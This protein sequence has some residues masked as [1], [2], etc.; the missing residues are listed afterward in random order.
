MSSKWD[1]YHKIRPYLNK[2]DETFFIQR[3][4]DFFSEYKINSINK[5]NVL[6]IGSGHGKFTNIFLQIFKQLTS[7]EPNIELY[8]KLQERY[9][10]NIITNKLI[11]FNTT[12]EKYKTNKKYDMII[13]MH[14]FL[15]LKDKQY[16]LNKISKMLKS[17]KYIMICEPSQF[18][19]FQKNKYKLQRMMTDTV[20]YIGKSR[21]FEVIYYGFIIKNSL[22]FLLKKI[23]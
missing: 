9:D 17:N 14:V 16:I 22:C 2:E 23:E 19:G 13:F 20:K 21:K 10:K 5:F 15:F 6:D 8:K 7:I 1:D 18:L 11:T 12:I 3:F 4:C